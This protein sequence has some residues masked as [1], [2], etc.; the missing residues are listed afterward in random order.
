MALS[1]TARD[2]IFVAIRFGQRPSVIVSV[3][4]VSALDFF[5]VPPRLTLAVADLKHLVTFAVMLCVGLITG[6]LAKHCLSIAARFDVLHRTEGR[7]AAS[8][9]FKIVH[10][11]SDVA[12]HTDLGSFFTRG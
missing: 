11:K 5:F 3:L 10:P 9:T 7:P 8:R 2:R 1:S 6:T 4:S 12:V